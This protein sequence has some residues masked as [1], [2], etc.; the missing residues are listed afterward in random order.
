[1]WLHLPFFPYWSQATFY[2]N[3]Q[4]SVQKS[5][6]IHATF[7]FVTNF[8]DFIYFYLDLMYHFNRLDFSTQSQLKYFTDLSGQQKFICVSSPNPCAKAECHVRQ[9]VFSLDRRVSPDLLLILHEVCSFS[10][11]ENTKTLPQVFFPVS[12]YESL[13][14]QEGVQFFY[15]NTQM[16]QTWDLNSTNMQK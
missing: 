2:H 9:S 14:W 8:T 3:I 12:F 7:S 16:K 5:S 4:K 6:S 10:V 15:E 11:T 1:M 13:A